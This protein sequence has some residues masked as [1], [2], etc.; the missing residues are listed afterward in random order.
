MKPLIFHFEILNE[1]LQMDISFD[2]Y[3]Y[4]CSP[5]EEVFLAL[6]SLRNINSLER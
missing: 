2:N 5:I 6:Q 1:N 4:L 3:T